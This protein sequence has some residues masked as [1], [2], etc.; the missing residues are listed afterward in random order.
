MYS[1]DRR[2]AVYVFGA[3]L[4][5]TALLWYAL[6]AHDVG[7]WAGVAKKPQ[8]GEVYVE[9][10]ACEPDFNTFPATPQIAFEMVYIPGGSF[11]MGSP[12]N[13]PGRE[14][15]EGPRHRV[16][17]EPF[18]MGKYEVTGELVEAW[19][20]ETR[21]TGRINT[22]R[23]SAAAIRA[24]SIRSGYCYVP[25]YQ[26]PSSTSPAVTLTC[27]GGQEFCRWLTRRTGR[28]Y[29]LPT[30]AEWE[31]ACRAGTSTAYHFGNDATKLSEYAWFGSEAQQIH[32]VGK[33]KSNP[34]GL[35]DMYGNAGEWVLD[36][37]T[38]SYSGMANGAHDPWRRRTSNKWGVIRGGDWC[39]E[40]PAEFRSASRY[41]ALDYHEMNANSPIFN[42]ESYRERKP[43]TGV[44]LVA[45]AIG[46]P[47]D[48][49]E[50]SVPP[51]ANPFLDLK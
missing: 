47:V 51:P 46:R 42:W 4:L 33:L 48:D 11:D 9:R 20:H 13:E 41:R 27:F 45:P 21:Q 16:T 7:V 3:S 31:Y 24:A 36:D 14:S 30:E 32:A 1:R 5:I 25:F 29:R 18:W 23:T 12:E 39:S 22:S 34:W 37:W 17:V 19:M 49:R 8:V 50:T 15:S 26:G 2:F 35:Y 38:D 28:F 44:R 10:I 40:T 6:R 43:Q